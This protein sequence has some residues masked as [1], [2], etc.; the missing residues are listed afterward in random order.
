M[1]VAAAI[2][3]PAAVDFLLADG[4][5]MRARLEG[6]CR[7]ADFYSGLYIRPGPDGQ[8]CADRDPIR[9][10][11]GAKCQIN[12]FKLLKPKR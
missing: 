3:V 10:R 7:S 1:I 6:D 12:T 9:I 11:S 5:W 4:R 2:A 8:V